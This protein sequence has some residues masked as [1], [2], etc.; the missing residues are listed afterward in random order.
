ME[1]IHQGSNVAGHGVVEG[2]LEVVRFHHAPRLYQAVVP[3]VHRVGECSGNGV[4]G[5]VQMMTVVLDEMPS[6]SRGRCLR[7]SK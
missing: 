7:S 1:Q 4:S 5:L 3:A 2:A 6:V